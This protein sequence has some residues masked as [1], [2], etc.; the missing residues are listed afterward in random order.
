[1]SR[2][3]KGSRPEWRVQVKVALQRIGRA[4]LRL[5]CQKLGVKSHVAAEE[6][7]KSQVWIRGQERME[8]GE[9]ERLKPHAEC[10]SLVLLDE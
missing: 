3:R 8:E 2:L 6:W 1:M 4:P 10:I 7:S 5:M 9:R